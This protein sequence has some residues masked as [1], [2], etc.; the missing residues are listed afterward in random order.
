MVAF[1]GI[2]ANEDRLLSLKRGKGLGLTIKDDIAK[3]SNRLSNV[4]RKQIPFA[5]ALT[6][7]RT[8]QGMRKEQQRTMRRVFDKPVRFTVGDADKGGSLAVKPANK[9]EVPVESR[10]FFTE[11]AAKGTP[12][13]KYLTPQI[14]GGQ[15][16]QKRHEL[17]LSQ[18]FGQ[19]IYTTPGADAPLLRNGNIS[20]GQYTRILAA[21]EALEALKVK[22]EGWSGNSSKRSRRRNPGVR[23]YYIARKGGKAI[24]VRQR[25][26]GG[27]SKKILNFVDRSPTYKPRYPFYKVGRAYVKKHLATNFRKSLR[28]ALRTAR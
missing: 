27:E 18:K 5:A 20:G 1:G 15:R 14:F 19:K 10:V 17:M 21:V 7:T 8:A 16:R 6:L 23:G 25:K 13:Y 24:G 28:T 3:L 2:K 4:Q 12:A 9:K 11:F 22:D 26:R